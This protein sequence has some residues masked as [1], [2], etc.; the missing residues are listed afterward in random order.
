MAI[1][2]KITALNFTFAI[3]MLKKF[4][5]ILLITSLFAVN[6]IRFFVMAGFELNKN[7][8]A[9]KLC[10]NRNKPWLHCNGRCYLMKK[11]KQAEEKQNADQRETQRNLFQEAFTQIDAQPGFHAILLQI[12]PDQYRDTVP[13][14]T[15]TVLLQPPQNS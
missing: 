10:E 13:T 11:L 5:A 4:A 6:C 14:P 8:I 15:T 2:L 1:P 7:Y 12:I 3:E 9:T